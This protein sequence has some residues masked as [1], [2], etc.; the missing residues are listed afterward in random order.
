MLFR[1]LVVTDG[2]NSTT[3]LTTTVAANSRL[4]IAGVGPSV[5][6]GPTPLQISVSMENLPNGELGEARID[7]VGFAT[8]GDF[9][10]VLF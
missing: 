8:V 7:A 4:D 3:A 1:S 9:A 2:T 10:T 6:N 5:L